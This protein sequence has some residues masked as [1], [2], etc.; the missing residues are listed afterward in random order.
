M[1]KFANLSADDVSAIMSKMPEDARTPEAGITHHGDTLSVPDKLASVVAAIVDDL[2]SA[3]KQ[4][5]VN[6]VATARYKKETEGL[7]FKGVRVDT[8]RASQA[9]ITGAVVKATIDNTFTTQWKG[10]DGT[11][12]ELDAAGVIALGNAVGSHVSACFTA[13]AAIV[14]RVVFGAITTNEQ[15]DTA[16]E[17]PNA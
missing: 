7:L 14:G 3:R 2:P 6:Y 16:A 12:V 8:S 4:L 11:F 13:E 9:M 15:I 17:W 10:S 5:L 1:K